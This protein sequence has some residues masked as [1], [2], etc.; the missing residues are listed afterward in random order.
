MEILGL[1]FYRS[2]YRSPANSTQHESLFENNTEF[3]ACF[4]KYSLTVRFSRFVGG[5]P[6]NKKSVIL[7]AGKPTFIL[8]KTVL[9]WVLR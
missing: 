5:T 8:V 6:K 7:S 3:T 4:K 2:T 9:A 1:S